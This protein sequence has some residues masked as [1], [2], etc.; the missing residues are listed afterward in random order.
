[1]SN[2]VS[3]DMSSRPASAMSQSTDRL[4]RLLALVCLSVLA[5]SFFGGCG[6]GVGG[7][8]TSSV[9]EAFADFGAKADTTCPFCSSAAVAASALPQVWVGQSSGL[10]V[11]LEFQAGSV[12]LEEGCK[13]QQ[14]LGEWGTTVSGQGRYYGVL[15]ERGTSTGQSSALHLRFL[16]DGRLQVELRDVADRVVLGPV[17]L[18]G[19]VS[20]APVPTCTA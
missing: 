2:P 20:S 4:S 6:P 17:T 18:S 15:S 19:S 11:R 8:G 13:A 10:A 16:P 9:V 14:F 5:L 1:M 3:R 7:T 12:R